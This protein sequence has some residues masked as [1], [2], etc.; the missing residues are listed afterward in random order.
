MFKNNYYYLVAGLPKLSFDVFKKHIA[1]AKFQQELKFQLSESDY[2]LAKLLFLENENKHFINI[3]LKKS[4]YPEIET[5]KL[6]EPQDYFLFFLE[7]A[8]KNESELSNLQVENKLH[9]LYY[10]HVLSTQNDFL[11]KWFWLDLNLKNILTAFNC[12][13]Y[14]LPLEKHLIEVEQ[15]KTVYSLLLNKP[16]N[17]R[18]FEDIVPYAK[19]IFSIAESSL[20][21]EEKEKQADK[22]LWNYAEELSC[23]HYFTIEKILCFIIK[24]RINKRWTKLDTDSGKNGLNNLLDEL[25]IS[26]KFSEEF[27]L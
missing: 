4:V 11:N 16:I 1:I 24:L 13:K 9:R 15:N 10:E 7:W 22:I 17:A 18:M 20:S 23:Y 8:K 6:P 5:L 14:K 21:A 2:G 27:A 26:N 12:K 25:E 3:H 19:E